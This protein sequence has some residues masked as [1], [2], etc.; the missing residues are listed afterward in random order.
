MTEAAATRAG[1]TGAGATALV[2]AALFALDGAEAVELDWGWALALTCAC[3]GT[4]LLA[5]APPTRA[6]YAGALARF[7]IRQRNLWALRA[8]TVATAPIAAAGPLAYA[9]LAFAQALTLEPSEREPQV[10]WRRMLGTGLLCLAFM[11]AI[12]EAGL[13]VAPDEVLWPLL[14]SAAGLSG[15]WWLGPSSARVRRG[16]GGVVVAVLFFYSLAAVGPHDRAVLGGLVGA[17]VIALVVAPRWLRSSRV[18]A[19]ERA[20]R[21]RSEE[22]AEVAAAV[23]DSVLQT[24]ALIQ[25][26]ADDPTE[27]RALART[28]ERDLRARLFGSAEAGAPA[29]SVAQALRAVAAEVEDSHRT[30][31]EVVTVGDAPLDERAAALVAA[32][33]EALVNSVRH[34]QGAPVSLFA[35]VDEQRVAAYVRDRGPGF[36]PERVPEDRRGITDSIIA[37]MKRHGGH[38]AVRTAPGG[39]CEVHL[40]LERHA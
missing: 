33:R 8:L 32:A 2:A 11:L 7:A 18:L 3:A 35:E 1:A 19:A 29:I 36:D 9:L 16:V 22:R 14:L 10:D 13:T 30:K 20:R 24:L 40:I 31:I 38:A 15:F 5:I 23:H 37:R 28:Q 17:S 26:R 6:L 4:A 12:S 34:A 25:S 21:A 27:V 39:G